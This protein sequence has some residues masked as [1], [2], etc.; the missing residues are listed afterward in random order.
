[1]K[2]IK[3]TV[4]SAMLAIGAA[5]PSCSFLDI[6]P[7][8]VSTIEHAFSSEIEAEKYLYTCYSF[9][10]DLANLAANPTLVAGDE[11]WMAYPRIVPQALSWDYIARN[12]QNSN[13]PVA[14]YW[15][16]DNE[17]QPYFMAIRECNTFLENVSDLSKVKDLSIDKRAR[18]IAEVKFLKA[19]YHFFLLRMYGPVPI[20]DKNL[21]ISA[22]AEK[23]QVRREPVDKC[24][25]YISDLLDESYKDLPSVIRVKAEYGR[26]DKAVNRAV[27][28]KLLLLAASPLFNG[29]PDYA[30]FT[31]KNGVPYFNPEADD[32]KWE[33]AADA[34]LEAI[35]EA[36][37]AGHE[38]YYFDKSQAGF[39][40]SETSVIQMNVRN[41]ICERWNKEIVWGLSDSRVTELQNVCMPRLTSEMSLNLCM[42]ALAPTMKIVRQFYTKNGVPVDEDVTLDFSNINE[43]RTPVED[44]VY[45]FNL[46]AQTARINFDREN[47]FYATMGFDGGKW[48]MS[49][50]PSRNDADAYVVQAKKNELAAGNPLALHSET[51]YFIKKLV[52][53]ESSF[54]NTNNHT[55]E[56][57]WPAI[58]L[59]DLYLM[60]AEALNEV[61]GPV[62]DVHK[63]VDLV[64][65]R[66]GLGT[67]YSSWETYSSNPSKPSTKSGM[68]EII[69]RERLIELCFEGTRLWDLK[70]WKTAATELNEP[71]LGWNITQPEAIDYYQITTLFQQ[72]FSIPRDYLTP[73][74]DYE[75]T[76]NPAL[77]Q[78]PG[79]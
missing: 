31:D 18:W 60:Y 49:D 36:H 23:V 75:L 14:N 77:V 45:N 41:A 39:N 17:G 1:M 62:D 38:L 21:P 12:M 32:T 15:D 67:V 43:L 70:R 40:L 4:I 76:V 71:V 35:N 63:Y 78:N 54:T 65:K 16:G 73:I 59:A 20:I 28:A 26:I 61:A 33:M 19:Y 24:V 46:R 22:E 72:K 2:N 6:V 66:A 57:P 3:I 8:D 48:L 27:K 42:A 56:Y 64:R 11:I 44:E 9:L 74:K 37:A 55:R 10:P 50:I 53:W 25:Q 47:R 7:D 69:R 34:A 30:G 5:F 58:R 52:S 51:G 29:N 79:W 68:R 13:R